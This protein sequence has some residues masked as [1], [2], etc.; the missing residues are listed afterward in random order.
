MRESDYYPAGAYND[1]NAPYNE[2]LVPDRNFDLNV[3]V[4]LSRDV[5]ITTNNYSP[6]FD[7]E[8]GRT[9]ANTENTEWDDE[10][11]E[12]CYTIPKLLEIL[13]GYV[14]QDLE[15]YKGSRHKEIQ[16]KE[17]L[18]ACDGWTVDELEVSEL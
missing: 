1:P 18:D 8:D 6:E 2:P 12:K 17:I 3:I 4:T 11:K 15:R 5:E 14:K 9:Y 13:K 7:E 16:L 10:Y